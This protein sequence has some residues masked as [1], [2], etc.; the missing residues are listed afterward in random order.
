MKKILGKTRKILLGMVLAVSLVTGTVFANTIQKQITA[1]SDPDKSYQLVEETYTDKNEKINV[2]IKYPQ[3]VNLGDAVKQKNINQIIKDDAIALYE[4]TLNELEDSSSYEADVSYEIKLKN[5]N[6][7]SIAYSSY[8]N[9]V[10]SA[11]PYFLFHTTNIDLTNG[12]KMTLA[13]IVPKMNEDFVKALRNAKYV[14][15]FSS[16]PQAVKYA[17]SYSF[18]EISDSELLKLL[19]NKAANMEIYGYLTKDGVGISVPVGHPLGDH[20]EFEISNSEL[21]K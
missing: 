11:H 19:S 7:L 1:T 6:I 18:G 14:G 2:K 16:D 17:I 4:E 12:K 21:P 8:N 20:A 3:I 5:D 13:D 10:P 15:M 9:I